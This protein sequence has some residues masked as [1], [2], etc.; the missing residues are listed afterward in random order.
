[1]YPPFF[2]GSTYITLMAQNSKTFLIIFLQKNTHKNCAFSIVLHMVFMRILVLS[3]KTK[4]TKEAVFYG[5]FHIIWI[6][7]VSPCLILRKFAR[8][9]PSVFRQKGC[10]DLDTPVSFSCFY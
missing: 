5:N 10:R 7:W 8:R 6:L 4:S 1:M 9:G 2:F 3:G